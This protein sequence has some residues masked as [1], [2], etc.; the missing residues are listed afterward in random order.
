MVRLNEADQQLADRPAH[1]DAVQRP[2]VDREPL[3]EI[4]PPRLGGL[5]VTVHRDG[6]L[7]TP[8]SLRVVRDH[9]PDL[10]HPRPALPDRPRTTPGPGPA[11]PITLVHP[12]MSSSGTRA[13]VGFRYVGDR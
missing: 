2:L 10:P 12:Y 6:P 7:N 4:A 8:A 11:I 3:D 1:P 13:T 9:D 5:G